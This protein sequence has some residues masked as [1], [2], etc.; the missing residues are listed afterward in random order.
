LITSAAAEA[1]AA[2]ALF[3]EHSGTERADALFRESAIAAARALQ[4]GVSAVQLAQL[5]GCSTA[6]LKAPKTMPRYTS[7]AAVG[8]HARTGQL[9]LKP[10][11][12]A[13]VSARQVQTAVRVVSTDHG[14]R[15]VD[16]IL[17]RSRSQRTAYA[18]LQKVL[19]GARVAD[20]WGPGA[21]G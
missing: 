3:F 8:Y 9:L 7:S 6:N 10:A 4:R 2:H 20:Q 11:P 13:P 18:A 15:A 21:P 1:A 14:T 12:A 16:D 5:Y 17:S 19:D